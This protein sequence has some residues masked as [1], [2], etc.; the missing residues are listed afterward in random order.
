MSRGRAALHPG[1]NEAATLWTSCRVRRKA[2]MPKE[3]IDPLQV[4]CSHLKS[5]ATSACDQSTHVFLR[6]AICKLYTM[7][8]CLACS[9]NNCSHCQQVSKLQS[10]TM[11]LMRMLLQVLHSH[12]FLR[13]C[14]FTCCSPAQFGPT[15][16]VLG[17]ID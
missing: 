4:L 13:R 17:P 7:L 1:Q 16:F 6:L 10:H 9:T 5:E 8:R 12:I 11:E 14:R 2:G 3:S 15:W